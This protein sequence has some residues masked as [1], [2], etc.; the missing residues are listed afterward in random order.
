MQ[1]NPDGSVNATA[2]DTEP[3]PQ[4]L[5]RAKLKETAPKPPQVKVETPAPAKPPPPP[6]PAMGPGS[7]PFTPDTHPNRQTLYALHDRTL[8]LHLGSPVKPW[9]K[10]VELIHKGFPD[11]HPAH[12]EHFRHWREN[13]R[14]FCPSVRK[15]KVK[16]EGKEGEDEYEFFHFVN[17]V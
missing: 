12:Y 8:I 16:E 15:K 13:A 9:E 2:P 6:K 14:K 5:E 10:H 3:S 7:Q 11:L 4:E 17:A 1:L